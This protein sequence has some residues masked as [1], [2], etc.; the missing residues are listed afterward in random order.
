MRIVYGTTIG[1]LVLL[2]KLLRTLCKLGF[3]QFVTSVILAS[4]PA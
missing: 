2:C 3:T 1:T 4:Q